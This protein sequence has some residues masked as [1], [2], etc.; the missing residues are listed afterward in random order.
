MIYISETTQSL[1]P[2]NKEVTGACAVIQLLKYV[3][4]YCI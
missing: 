4:S 1:E 3:T 2:P